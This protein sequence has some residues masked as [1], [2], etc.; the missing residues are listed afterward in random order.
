MT[1]VF[2]LLFVAA[3]NMQAQ[4]IKV[5]VKDETGEGIFG[6]TVQEQGTSNG[7][8]TNLDGDMTITLKNANNPI[9]ISY[10]GMKS[11]TVKAEGRSVIN[12]VLKDDVTMLNDV[13]VIGYGTVRKKD[14][15]GAVA[16]ISADKLADIPVANIGEALTGKLAGVNITTTE[17]S[18]DADVK[19]RVRG[20][21]SLS[22]DNSPLYIVD[23]FPV[24]SI[25][26]IAPSEIESIDVLKDASSTAIY[27]ARGANGVIII[28]TKSGSEGN[29]Q[30]NF[31]ASIGWKKLTKEIKV[32]DP[33]NYA[34]YQYELG[35]E[36]YGNYD[37]LDIWKSVEGSNWQ[38]QIFAV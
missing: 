5:N 31:N 24:E 8:T 17:G 38:D 15:T 36:S 34:Y 2:A 14:L 11:Q 32:L 3:A 10:L 1:L 37:D 33:Y 30:V 19:I 25:S 35:N 27:G 23:G 18:P 26:D 21:G 12:I 28:T 13:V 4:T 9:V 6:A 16:S 7:G 22:Q 20:G 29:V